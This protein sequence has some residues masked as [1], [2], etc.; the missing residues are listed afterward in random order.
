MTFKEYLY[1][2]PNMEWI[3]TEF[4]TYLK[5]F[6]TANDLETQEQAMKALNKLRSKFHTQC[7][8]VNIRHSI[9]ANDEFY[10][11]EQDYIDTIKPIF[12]GYVTDYYR[13]LMASPFRLELEQRWGT[14]LFQLAEQAVRAFHPDIIEDLQQENKLMT[15]YN[16]LI[17]SAKIQF[18]G[19]ERTL[20]QLDPFMRAA[21]RTMRQ[22]ASEAYYRFME[23]YELEFDRI[24][25]DLV[26]VRT[27]M[28]KKLGYQN[29]VELGY[30]RM[31]RTDYNAKMVANFR[32]QVLDQIVPLASRLRERQCSRIGVDTLRY[33]DEDL[34]FKDGNPTLKGDSDWVV[35]NSAKMYAEMSPETNKFFTFMME[36]G[37]MDLVSK[38]G[39]QGGG[40]SAFLSDYHAPFVFANFNG[41]SSDIHDLTHETGHAFQMYESRHFQVPEYNIP[42]YEA[43]EIHS[44]SMDFF[45]WPWLKLFFEEEADKY[46]FHHL[47]SAVLFLP[48]GAS[49][50]EFQHF[51][52][53]HPERTPAERREAWL[54]IE[55]K[56]LPERNYEGCEYLERGGFWH[57]Q[58]HIFTL[59]FYYID[60][61]LAEIC[62]LQFLKRLIRDYEAAWADYLKLC[63][64]G[65]SKSFTNLVE[66]AGLMSPFE[67]GCIASIV[68]ALEQQLYEMD[69]A[70]SRY[71][72]LQN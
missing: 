22:R 65:G 21:D 16:K 35:A 69:D 11:I 42:T 36:N 2:R 37:L 41:S 3:G 44:M 72:P 30:A 45:A 8:L 57:K 15:E 66:V 67:D 54:N 5:T 9:D 20:V 28:A 60:Y 49:I 51:I 34:S 24:L 12:Q 50:D 33:Y 26:K 27:G 64:E 32:L 25:D 52:Y 48:Y 62:A 63:R 19:D 53:E 10:R 31:N 70:I 4:K 61:A 39:K 38:K 56:Y 6:S 71:E 1:E 47:T 43:A 7:Q 23:D 46:K 13:A 68:V 18:E 58:G 55:R 29:Y 14:Q 17:A 40:Y 59:P